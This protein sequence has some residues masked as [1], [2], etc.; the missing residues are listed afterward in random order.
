MIKESPYGLDWWSRTVLDIV[1]D[2]VDFVIIHIYRPG[3]CRSNEDE[4]PAEELC[5]K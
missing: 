5:S 2:K 3:Y 4:L 1:K